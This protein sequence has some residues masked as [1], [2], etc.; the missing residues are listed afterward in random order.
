MIMLPSSPFTTHITTRH[1]PLIFLQNRFAYDLFNRGLAI[2]D[3]LQARFAQRL[4]AEFL[5]RFTQ[6][7]GGRA[8]TDHVAQIVVH[9]DQF[10]DA[11]PA[12]MPRVAAT[13][14]TSAVVESLAGRNG[15]ALQAELH[16]NF[17][18]RI[19]FGAAILA[20]LADQALREDAF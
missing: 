19:E 14:A 2:V 13:V 11:D 3:R 4:H 9:A 18:A 16:Q 7:I 12:F 1:S 20:N 6:L 8:G 5:A 17:I 10:E 15:R